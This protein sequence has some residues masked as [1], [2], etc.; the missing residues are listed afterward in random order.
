MKNCISRRSF[1]KAAGILGAAGALAACGGSS[2]TS[3]A[4]SSTASSAAA[5]AASEAGFTFKPGTYT[6][7]AYGNISDIELECTFS[8]TALTDVKIVGQNETPALFSQVENELIPAILDNQA[9]GV[10]SITGATNSS[11]AVKEAIADCVAQAGGD[12]QAWLAKTVEKTAGAAEEYDVDVAVIGCGAAGFMASIVAA[13]KGMKVL[14]VEKAGSVAGVNGIK[15]SGPFA[16]D[17]SVLHAREGGTTLTVDEVF[18][19][20]MNYTHWT[21]NPSLIKRCLETSKD[22]VEELVGIGYEMKEANF[23]FETPFKDEK[24]GFHL[25]TNAL[26]ERVQLWEKA[27]DDNGVQVIYNT[28]AKS[29]IVENDKICGFTA[30]KEDG[31]PITVHAGAVIIAS[32]GFL[33]N[34]DL[35]EKFLHTRKLNAAAGG[36]SLCTGDGIVMANDA[37]AVLCK[38]FGY[39]PC[40]YGGTNSKAST[41]ASSSACTA[42]CWWTAKASALSTRACC[43]ITP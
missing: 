14:T 13:Q 39:C 20:A 21:P 9:G 40:E 30:E 28:A 4:A 31:T 16:V 2:S 35:Q 19:H 1:L 10:D 37:G 7:K 34:R 24:G 29:L 15:V 25:I 8:E 11:R 42:T 32:G 6:A 26:D 41:T 33:G 18:N 17:T 43:A 23:R 3:T 36:N 5:S 22:A 27:L 12:R 38:T